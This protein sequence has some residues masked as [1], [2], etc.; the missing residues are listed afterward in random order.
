MMQRS[1]RWP[2]FEAVSLITWPIEPNTFCA[3]GLASV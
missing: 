3:V 1:G 2:S